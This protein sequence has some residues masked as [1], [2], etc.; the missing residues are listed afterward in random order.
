MSR[1]SE[2]A[3]LARVADTGALSNRNLIINGA[4]QVAQRGTSGSTPTTD[5]YLLDRFSL[6]RFGGYPDNATQ[7]Q[8]SDAPTGHYKSFKM[9]RNSGHTLTGTNAS[10]FFQ[11]VEGQNIA[12]LNWGTSSAQPIVVSFW[13]KSNKTGDF[14]FIVADSGNAYDIGKL[15]NIASANTWEYKTIQIE[16]PTSGTFNTNNTVGLTMYWGFGAIDASRTAQGTTWGVSNSSS[17]KSMVTGAS[18]SLATDNGAT[19][20]ITGVQLEVGDTATEF[21]H[22]SYGDELAR[23]QRYYYKLQSEA[24]YSFFVTG[25][26]Y[27][28]TDANFPITFP[29]KLR[30][31][32]TFTSSGNWR[33]CSGSCFNSPTLSQGRSAS[34]SFSIVATTSGLTTG[35]AYA[36]GDANDTTAYLAFDAEL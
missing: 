11:R 10:A 32:P 25:Y 27:Q 1:Q 33:I 2:L 3:A 34:N 8:E 19:W 36:L 18:T 24:A 20:Q 4:M 35:D 23:C 5:N 29:Q 9:V 26:A 31:A 12:H 13:V 22:R 15:Y 6:S 14:P 16:A 30:A 17:S 21:E 7:T 28:S